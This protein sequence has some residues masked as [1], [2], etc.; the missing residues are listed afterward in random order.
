MA[1]REMYDVLKRLKEL[2][3]NNPNVINDAVENTEKMN[4]PVEE[5]KKA[6]PDFLDMD[7]DGDK[8]EPMKKAIK[9]KKKKMDEAHKVSKSHV[10]KM[11]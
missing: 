2:D 11:V 9:D 5:A 6:K 3:K 8:K 7:K 4:P 10:E 1:S